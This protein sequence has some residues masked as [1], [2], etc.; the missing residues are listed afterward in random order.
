MASLSTFGLVGVLFY[1]AVKTIYRLFFHPLRNFPG[2]KLAAATSAYEGYF[3]VIKTGMFI[4]EL[5]RLHN[6]YGKTPR[7]TK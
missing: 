5:E 2:P 3:N 6:V 7:E 4:W 1:F